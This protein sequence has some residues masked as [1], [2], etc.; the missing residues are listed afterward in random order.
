V[1]PTPAIPV[2]AIEAAKHASTAQLLF[3]VARLV[4]DRGLARLRAATGHDIRAAHT[5][6]F[7]H[8]DLEGTRLTVLARRVGVSKQAV[9]QLVDELARMGVME[10]V[11][12]PKDGRAKLIRFAQTAD[13][14]H[15]ILAGLRVL[16]EVEGELEAH[17]GAPAWASLRFALVKLLPALE[18]D[19][20]K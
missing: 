7:P 13:G 3:R 15:G 6:L 12:D 4:N 18:S 9:G 10:R 8:V 1:P 11:P 19:S 5:N 20:I 16:G 17:I 2:D 14:E